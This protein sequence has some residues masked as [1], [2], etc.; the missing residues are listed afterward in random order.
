MTRH[1]KK[2]R[3]LTK[4]SSRSPG[5]GSDASGNPAAGTA[6]AGRC[7]KCGACTAACPVFQATGR[8]Y[9]GGRGK[10]HLLGRLDPATASETYADILSRCL[11]CGACD[12]ACSRGIRLSDEIVAARRQLTR[13]AGEH[14]FL[15]FL[16][17]ASLA[18]PPLTKGL[19]GLA[20][21]AGRLP[22]GSGLRLR[23]GLLS[24]PK[25]TAMP[26][27]EQYAP[28]GESAVE[29]AFFGGCFA[30]YLQPEIA[31]ATRSLCQKLGQPTPIMMDN[32]GC[33]GLAAHSAGDLATAQA[34][35]RRNIEAFSSTDAPILTGCAS[36]FSHL[37]HY[38]AL[39]VD[40]PI[41]RERAET[42]A[43]RL[44]EFSTF[45]L[46]ACN[47]QPDPPPKPL[48]A[49]MPLR[50]LYHDPCHLRF[51]CRITLPPR[52]LLSKFPR[53]TLIELPR[54]PQCCGHGGLFHLAHPDVAATIH[55]RLLDDLRCIETE[56]VTTT[57][58]GCLLQL[59]HGPRQGCDHRQILHLAPLLD[60][61]L[62]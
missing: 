2:R 48:P 55:N 18:H 33:C 21:L 1:R 23:L 31:I 53:V 11:L 4:K 19:A 10:L 41:W 16:A 7:A 56:L 36:C 40:E 34:L 52:S 13:P 45:M 9:H 37:S 14:G 26:T 32:Q 27:P 62:P 24:P 51:H 8:E 28:A 59:L 22:P 42:F 43:K 30:R 15:R 17:R 38:P 47:T 57:C 5:A 29:L 3:A 60:A 50:V 35:A 46:A 39:F 54:G 44:V 6:S 12:K 20:R 25:A 61:L 49:T 58:S